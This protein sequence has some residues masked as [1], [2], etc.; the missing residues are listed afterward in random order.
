[1]PLSSNKLSTGRLPVLLILFMAL[2]TGVRAY[3][4]APG[5]T[6]Y[7]TVRDAYGWVVDGPEALIAI[8]D[9]ATGGVITKSKIS[10]VASLGENYRMMLPLDHNRTGAVYRPGAV[11]TSTAFT[12]EVTLAGITYFPRVVGAPGHSPAQA[13]QFL[14]LD[15]TLGDDSDSD[16]LPDLWEQWQ[17][18][19]AGLDASRLDLLTANGDP[20]GDG[21]TNGAEFIAGTFAFLTLDCLTLNFFE[22]TPDDWSRMG[23]LAVIGKTY[24]LEHSADMTNWEPAGFGLSEE[25]TQLQSTWTAPDTIRQTIQTPPGANGQRWFFRLNVR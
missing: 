6:V 23:F 7:G 10:S 18:E 3:P 19:A 21:M 15:L 13:S 9:A 25:R 16:G 2:L 11:N 1:M 22:I 24:T 14:H 12:I 8:K 20:D 17:L 5:C 4:P